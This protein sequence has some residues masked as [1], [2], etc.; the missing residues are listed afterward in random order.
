MSEE[1]RTLESKPIT[2]YYKAEKAAL[3]EEVSKGTLKKQ[4]ALNGEMYVL[5]LPSGD[6]PVAIS[7]KDIIIHSG[8]EVSLSRPGSSGDNVEAT[9]RIADFHIDEGNNEIEFPHP[10]GKEILRVQDLTN[11]NS[12]L[13]RWGRQQRVEAGLMPS[14]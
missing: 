10:I 8:D 14:E 5:P 3:D 1:K 9:F 12:A 2:E 7:V 6:F 13:V 11:N 4:S